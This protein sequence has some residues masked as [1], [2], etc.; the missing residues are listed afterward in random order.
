M[1]VFKMVC[2]K[3]KVNPATVRVVRVI[4]GVKQELNICESCAKAY[5][6]F[7]MLGDTKLDSPF[8]FQNVLS[9]LV[10]YINQSSTSQRN[11]EEACPKCGMPYSEFKKNG[12]MGCS[13]CY[14]SFASIVTPVI[15]RVQSNTD[16]IGKLPLKSGKLI[17]EKKLM[18]KLKEQLQKSILNEEFEEAAK[19]RDQIRELQNNNK[20]V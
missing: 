19:I 6:G 16:H 12:L 10:D 17:M 8:T 4:N 13:D 11:T 18:D 3:C 5:Q 15:K 1:E 2:E 9:G 20:E 7:S 14:R